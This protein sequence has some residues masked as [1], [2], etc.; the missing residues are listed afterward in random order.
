MAAGDAKPIPIKNAA[1]RVTFPLFDA[2]GDLV[3]GGASD[4]PDTE[5]SIDQGTFADCSNEMIE[6]ATN[7]G[8]YYLDLNASEMNGDTIAIIAKTATAGTKTT[9]LV[10]YT[11]AIGFD[12][13]HDK[14]QSDIAL[15]STKMASDILALEGALDSDFLALEGALDSDF[16]AIETK[17]NSD[18]LLYISD[19]SDIISELAVLDAAIDSDSVLYL[20]DHDK[21]QSDIAL[22]TLTAGAIADAV[23]DEK[24]SDHVAAGTTGEALSDAIVAISDVKSELVVISDA[25]LSDSLLYDTDHDKTQSDIALLSTKMAS[26]MLALETKLDSDMVLETAD[27]DK[28]QSDLAV[29]QVDI[30][31]IKAVTDVSIYTASVDFSVDETN[32]KD[33]YLV[34]WFTNGVPLTSGVT[35]PKIQVIKRSDGTD[36]IANTAMTEITGGAYKYDASTTARTTAGEGVI[37]S[38]TAT[39]GA[40]TRTWRVPVSR[41]SA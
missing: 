2:D 30:D 35:V 40:A 13:E 24:V 4:T 37:V 17:I 20:A 41:D 28:T 12:A 38:V 25:I 15:L 19:L 31:A 27:H 10:L 18:S 21:T 29:A 34:Q 16:L 22:I 23:W 14:T 32:S 33:E 7:S 11:S 8:M 39:I 3:T 5:R 9:P 36:L 26:D 6:I 1:Y